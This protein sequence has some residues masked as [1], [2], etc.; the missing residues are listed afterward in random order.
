ME[1]G[2]SSYQPWY[3]PLENGFGFT[4][5]AVEVL[6]LVLVMVDYRRK[7][8]YTQQLLTQ[9]NCWPKEDRWQAFK[10]SLHHHGSWHT[11]PMW[12]FAFMFQTVQLVQAQQI[13]RSILGEPVLFPRNLALLRYLI[14]FPF[15]GYAEVYKHISKTIAENFVSSF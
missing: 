6:A 10:Y 7:G 9:S 15:P 3:F 12:Q 14:N 4:F 2:T 11:N 13:Q 8:Q 5:R 1:N